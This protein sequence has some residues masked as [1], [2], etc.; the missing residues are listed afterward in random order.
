MQKELCGMAVSFSIQND[1]RLIRVTVGETDD[2]DEMLNL[3]S[4]QR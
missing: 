1:P 4:Q 3:I 2:D